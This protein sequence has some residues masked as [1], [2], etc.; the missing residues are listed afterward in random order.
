M[1]ELHQDYCPLQSPMSPHGSHFQ[2]CST[3]CCLGGARAPL[4]ARGGA[5]GGGTPGAKHM[6]RQSRALI[7]FST[8]ASSPLS[9]HPFWKCSLLLIYVDGE[10][11]RP[12]TAL[13]TPPWGSGDH[14]LDLGSRVCRRSRCRARQT[15]FGVHSA[16]PVTPFSREFA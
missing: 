14:S 2:P 15:G 13:V 10:L 5:G 4:V 11:E 7:L 6:G 8:L 12:G 3:C 16:C 1:R 9:P